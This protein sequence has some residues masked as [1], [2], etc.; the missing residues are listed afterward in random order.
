MEGEVD[1]LE[2]RS[3]VGDYPFDC[4]P[5]MMIVPTVMGLDLSMELDNV[6]EVLCF[7]DQAGEIQNS[8]IQ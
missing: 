8:S 1:F 3:R 6:N 4:N 2:F 7:D 5:L